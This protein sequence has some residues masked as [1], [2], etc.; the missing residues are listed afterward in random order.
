V[1]A[2]A[3]QLPLVGVLAVVAA[4]LVV[5]ALG[6]WRVGAL[7]IGVGIVLAGLLRLALPVRRVGLLAV[8]SRR[9]D[10]AVLLLLGAALVALAASVPSP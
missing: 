6:A 10:V 1:P 9:L 4:G 3:R 8:R 5:G 2:P 7:A